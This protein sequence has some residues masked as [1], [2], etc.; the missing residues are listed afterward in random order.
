MGNGP[1]A[2]P[3]LSLCSMAGRFPTKPCKI[4]DVE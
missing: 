3:A 4:E 1:C 2:S